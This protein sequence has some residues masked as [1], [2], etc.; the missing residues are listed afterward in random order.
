MT[1]S[2]LIDAKIGGDIFSMTNAHMYSFGRHAK[3]LPGREDGAI[4]QG[5]KEDGVTPNDIAVDAMTYYMAVA[6]ITEEFV[7]DAS[8]VKLREVSLGYS[9]PQKW[10]KKLGMSALSLSVVGRNLWNIY[11]KVPLVDPESSF[12]T[13]NAQGFE[14]YGMPASRSIGFNLNVKF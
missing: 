5:V 10:I 7:Y 4:G 8:Y 13:G 2:F 14:S 9:F 11:D 12:N 6:G 1:L 3:T